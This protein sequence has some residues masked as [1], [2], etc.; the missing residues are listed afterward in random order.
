MRQIPIGTKGIYT[1]VLGIE[2]LASSANPALPEVMATPMMILTMEQAAMNALTAY[3]EPGETSVGMVV[4]VEHL[5]A[6]P[7]GHTVRGE[8]EVVKVEGRR[9]EFQV[10][11]FDEQEQIGRGTHGRAVIDLQKF[12]QRLQAKMRP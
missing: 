7:I 4:N 5:A 3:L 11:A 6:T 10:A 9:I 12:N 2:H 8:A 1:L